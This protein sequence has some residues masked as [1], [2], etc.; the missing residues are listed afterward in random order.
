LEYYHI[1]TT[2]IL[3]KHKI[4]EINDNSIQTE[5]S[6]KTHNKVK[7]KYLMA[8]CF[9]E[10]LAPHN[11]YLIAP[12]KPIILNLREEHNKPGVTSCVNCGDPLTVL[13]GMIPPYCKVCE[14]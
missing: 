14:P 12:E 10:N 4:I 3:Y 2:R 13:G 9:Y 1:A 7:G 6:Y 5:Y 8:R 11:C